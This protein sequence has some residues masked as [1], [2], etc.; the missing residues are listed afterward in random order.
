ML[1]PMGINYLKLNQTTPPSGVSPDF[2]KKHKKTRVAAT[3]EVGYLIVADA[4]STQ[5][6]GLITLPAPAMIK[7]AI[8]TMSITITY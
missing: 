7:V 6:S 1:R 2:Q 5:T 4:I 3:S 8:E